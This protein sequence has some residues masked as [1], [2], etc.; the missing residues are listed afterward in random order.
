MKLTYWKAACLYDSNCYSI[1]AKTKKECKRLL[2][3][4]GGAGEDYDEV[5]KVVIEY[6]DGFDLM[7]ELIGYEGGSDY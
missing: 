3:E 6:K 7:M 5:E 4:A 1:R 2:E